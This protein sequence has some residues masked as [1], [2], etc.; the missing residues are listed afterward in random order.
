MRIG[1]IIIYKDYR[2][3]KVKWAKDKCRYLIKDTGLFFDTLNQTKRFIDNIDKNV[4]STYM[5]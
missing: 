5:F 2:I 1:E 4:V 3:K